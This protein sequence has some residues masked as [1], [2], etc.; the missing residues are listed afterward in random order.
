MTRWQIAGLLMAGG[1][2][3]WLAWLYISPH[4]NT[5]PEQDDCSFGPVSNERYRELLALARQHQ[6]SGR[7]SRLRGDG[8]DMNENLQ[9]RLDDIMDGMD[10]IYERIAATHAVMRA[11]GAYYRATVPDSE[12]AFESARRRSNW[13][14]FGSVGFVY[15]L[16]VHRIGGFAPILRDARI[17]VSFIADKE[18]L[19]A[20]RKKENNTFTVTINYPFT[21]FKRSLRPLSSYPQSAQ[22]HKTCP[23]VPDPEWLMDYEQWLADTQNDRND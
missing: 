7:W 16:D 11:L 15:F 23:A 1:I 20:W 12:D 5:Y 2:S 21:I 6:A 10:S 22:Y 4:F 13:T 17:G 3:I 8:P 14:E 18:Q 19:A 9:G